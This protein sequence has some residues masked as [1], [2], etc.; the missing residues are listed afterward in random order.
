MT[1]LLSM[2]QHPALRSTTLA[3]AN[4][5]FTFGS[6]LPGQLGFLPV[7]FHIPTSLS[8]REKEEAWRGEKQQGAGD[9]ETPPPPK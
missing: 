4:A 7:P 8:F 2:V 5:E 1:I 6:E 9:Q 3:G